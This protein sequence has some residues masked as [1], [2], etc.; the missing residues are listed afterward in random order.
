MHALNQQK[1]THTETFMYVDQI[2]MKGF[3]SQAK[4]FWFS[5]FLFVCF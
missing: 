4:G 5:L 1:Y 2:G 3:N